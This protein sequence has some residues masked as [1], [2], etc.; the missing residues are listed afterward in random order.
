MRADESRDPGHGSD[1][2]LF[3]EGVRD[4][5][6][7]LVSVVPFALITGVAATGAGLAPFP[8]IMMSLLVFAGAAQL[9]AFQLLS[10]GTPLLVILVATFFVNLRMALY[11]LSLARIFRGC[12]LW[13]RAWMGHLITD[14]AFVLSVK[15]FQ[16]HP[17]G[18]RGHHYY[19]GAALSMLLMWMVFYTIGVYAGGWV[20]A[21]WSLEFAIPLTFMVLLFAGLTRWPMVA[22]AL[23]GGTV[24]VCAHSLPYNLGLIVGTAAGI[25][26]GLLAES[27]KGRE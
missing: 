23:C 19:F 20:P 24:A 9:V 18:P 6:P 7:L 22:A 2:S 26:G 5:M 12:S 8:A 11:S 10:A 17:S 13:T 1:H 4:I 14:H 25:V 21:S 3:Y 16:L 15:R 27:R